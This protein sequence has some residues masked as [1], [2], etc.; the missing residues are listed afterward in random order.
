MTDKGKKHIRM[1]DSRVKR[2]E[3]DQNRANDT[4]DCTEESMNIIEGGSSDSEDIM[5]RISKVTSSLDLQSIEK[6]ML[7]RMLGKHSHAFRGRPGL[8]HTYTLMR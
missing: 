6:D 5:V 4:R 2:V 7:K 3:P 1:L 8:T